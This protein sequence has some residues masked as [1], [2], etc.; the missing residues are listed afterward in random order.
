MPAGYGH[1]N[2]VYSQWRDFADGFEEVFEGRIIAN[3]ELRIANCEFL[4]LRGKIVIKLI[5]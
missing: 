5:K 4:N 2:R 3:F 1:G